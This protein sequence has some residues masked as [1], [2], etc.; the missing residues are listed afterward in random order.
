M[1]EELYQA[2]YNE[3]LKWCR[4]MTGSLSLA[5]E[6]VQE[7]YLRALVNEETLSGLLEEQRRAWLYRTMKNIYVDRC[8]HTSRET[9]MEFLPKTREEGM[10]EQPELKNL[11][12]QQLLSTLPGEEELLFTMRYLQGYNSRQLSELFG[13]PQGTVRSKL[14]SAR[15]HLREAIG[16]KGYV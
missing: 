14:S 1:I 4:N 2:Y 6:I 10:I 15:K 3:L 16:G 12:W 8:R 9:V 11:E 13:M 7:G 5:E